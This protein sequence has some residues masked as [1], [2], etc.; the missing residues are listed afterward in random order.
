VWFVVEFIAEAV[1]FVVWD[2]VKCFQWTETKG[3]K[4]VPE[5]FP[6]TL[7]GSY[8]QFPIKCQMLNSGEL[9][10][11][12][13]GRE[14]GLEVLREELRAEIDYVTGIVNVDFHGLVRKCERKDEGVLSPAVARCVGVMRV[15]IPGDIGAG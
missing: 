8:P 15:M 3:V 14:E 13:Y 11:L 4:R 2:D 6:T 1:H 5:V 12:P 10:A 7:L 9:E